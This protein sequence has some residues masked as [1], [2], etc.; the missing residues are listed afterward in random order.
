MDKPYVTVGELAEHLGCQVLGNKNKKIFEIS[1][2]QD[3]NED[4]LTYVPYQ[5]I[6]Q[7][8]DI[9]AGAILTKVSIGLPLHRNY[10]ICKHEPHEMLP[11]VIAFLIEKGLYG[12]EISEKPMLSE[13]S[14]VAETVSIQNGAIIGDHTILSPGISI[15]RNVKIGSHCVIGANTVIGDHCT[16]GNDVQI[17]VSYTHLT[18]PTT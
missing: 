16:I 2:Y 12:C 9:G 8:P 17:A 3:S 18:L 5:K 4:S 14:E 10:I 13:T 7:I 6:N 11:D 15:G 1:L